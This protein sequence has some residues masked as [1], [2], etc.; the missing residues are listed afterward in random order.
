[1]CAVRS[2]SAATVAI[3]FGWI[4]IGDDTITAGLPVL[5]KWPVSAAVNHSVF[6]FPQSVTTTLLR[7]EIEGLS[8]G[9]AS[10]GISGPDLGSAATADVGVV[11]IADLSAAVLVAGTKFG[12]HSESCYAY[13]WEPVA[14]A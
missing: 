13:I 5:G 9:A 3:A 12:N 4:F 1:M 8:I 6:I 14:A 11:V 10:H 2:K 7:P